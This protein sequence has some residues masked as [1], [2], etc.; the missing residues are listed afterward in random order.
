MRLTELINGDETQLAGL[1]EFGQMEITGLTCDSRMVRPGFLFAAFPGKRA[2]GREFIAEALGR[3]ASAVLA[4]PGTRLHPPTQPANLLTVENPRRA[5]AL[6]A[7][8]FYQFQPQS[9][10]A[11]TG[12]NGKTSTVSFLQ[13]M[14]TRLGHEA[15]SMG[16]LGVS[17]PGIEVGGNLTTPDAVEIHRVLREIS[18]AGID[19]LAMEASS[20]GLDQFRLDGVRV[21]V[22]GFTNLSRDHLDYHGS[23]ESYASAKLRLI[24]DLVECGGTVVINADDDHAEMFMDAAQRRGLRVI[25]YGRKGREIRLDAVKANTG[26]Q[27]LQLEILGDAYALELPLVGA[28]QAHNALCALGLAIAS[29]E[30]AHLA[31]ATLEHLEGVRGRLELC[32]R[33]PSGAPV[34]IDYAH[35]PD[36]L[37][38]VLTTLRPHVNGRL[39]VVFG[40]GGDRDAGKRPIMGRVAQENADAVFV[41][42]DNPRSENAANIRAKI[43]EA[44]DGATEIADRAQAITTAISGMNAGDLLVV[45]GKGHETGQIV[46]SEVLPFDDA[47]VVRRAIAEVG[48]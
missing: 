30:D 25:S 19:R 35:T 22:A 16:T 12:T 43:L 34:F 8:R 36:A 40:C 18:D 38:S 26:G 41:T 11:V 5:F 42:D 33:H 28:F 14:W 45:A 6:M 20:H 47:Q 32:A 31:A 27:K 21:S 2:D 15:A 39:V 4:P 3:G 24:E 37:N 46:G 44:C 1:T 48:P 9:I 17:G 29:G 23:M 13:Q 10:A 7:A